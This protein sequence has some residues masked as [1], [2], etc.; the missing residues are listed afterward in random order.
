MEGH[1]IKNKQSLSS[2][3]SD[4]TKDYHS[5]FFPKFHPQCYTD[6][7]ASLYSSFIYFIHICLHIIYRSR[8]L[9]TEY[10]SFI[11]LCFP[12]FDFSLTL[13][14]LQWSF[15]KIYLLHVTFRTFA[16]ATDFI[17]S[18]N[19]YCMFDYSLDLLQVQYITSLITTRWCWKCYYHSY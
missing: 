16:L 3:G 9:P 5:L 8:F 10:F 15:I 4:P 13:T 7:C 18:S 11:S 14:S 19:N 2:S 6:L 12:L 17:Y 1:Q